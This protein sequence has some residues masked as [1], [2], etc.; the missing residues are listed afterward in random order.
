MGGRKGGRKRIPTAI[1][2]LQG[3]KAKSHRP[4]P[5][6]EPMPEAVVPRCPRHLDKE[7]R[8][9]WRRM[10][11]EL[12]PLGL[13]TN[14]DKAILASYC[15]AWSTW[16]YATLKIREKGL[17]VMAST[18]TPMQN[19]Y[20][21]IINKANEQMVRALTE[22]GMSPSSRSRVTVS[23]KAK[24]QNKAEEFKSRKNGTK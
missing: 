4:L 21:P 2:K 8:A 3:G 9:E 6:G 16:A 5:E 22:I 17:I 7:A 15:Q 23:G 11:K 10:V 13:L 18:G 14:L 19:P 24:K 12:E 20:W 1:H